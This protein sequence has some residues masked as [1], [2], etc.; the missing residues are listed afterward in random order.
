MPKVAL[1]QFWDKLEWQPQNVPVITNVSAEQAQIRTATFQ[2]LV[3]ILPG[4]VGVIITAKDGPFIHSFIV[5]ENEKE[6]LIML[7]FIFIF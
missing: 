5:P 1:K 3:E 7:L 2:N 4:R 6:L